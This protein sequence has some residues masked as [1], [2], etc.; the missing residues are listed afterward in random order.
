M[1]QRGMVDEKVRAVGKGKKILHSFRFLDFMY[2]LLVSG[3]SFSIATA[4]E[5]SIQ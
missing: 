2:N 1:L 5:I 3:A 4:E